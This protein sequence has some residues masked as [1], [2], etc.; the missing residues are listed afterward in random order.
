MV[1]KWHNIFFKQV[2]VHIMESLCDC[3]IGWVADPSPLWGDINGAFVSKSQEWV[4]MLEG[5]G[6]G[7]AVP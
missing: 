4:F 7:A 3:P 5:E 1:E 6:T 2:T